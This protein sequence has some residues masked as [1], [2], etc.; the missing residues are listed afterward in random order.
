MRRPW[1]SRITTPSNGWQLILVLNASLLASIWAVAVYLSDLVERERE[2]GAR[3]STDGD[4][5]GIPLA[6]YAVVVLVSAPLLNGV[7][8][9]LGRGIAGAVPLLV[10]GRRRFGWRRLA[11]EG[12]TMGGVVL[13]VWILRDAVWARSAPLVAVSIVWVYLLAS[14]R[15]LAIWRADRGASGEESEA[16]LA[17]GTDE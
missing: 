13:L 3:V 10:L 17:G 8:V 16:N 4:S 12:A 2:I 5:L 11:T 9:W 14:A 1:S 7:F 15:A 6:G